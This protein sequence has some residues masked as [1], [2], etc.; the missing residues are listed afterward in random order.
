M[1]EKKKIKDLELTKILLDPRRIS[2]LDIAG[3]K[4]VTVTQMAEILNEKPSRLYY[5]VKKLEEAGFLE[6]VETKQQGN[7]IEKYYQTILNSSAHEF[8]EVLLHEHSE[9]VMKLLRQVVS[10]GLKLI[11]N[12]IT[13]SVSKEEQTPVQMSIIYKRKTIREWVESLADAT[14]AINNRPEDH[15]QVIEEELKR[16]PAEMMDK[17]SQYAYV[18]LSYRLEDAKEF[19]GKIPDVMLDSALNVQEED[20]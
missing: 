10:P 20:S 12:R 14:V 4:P 9:E 3:E 6:L 7:L 17:K 5:H 18:I 16:Y 11:E 19:G 2:I 15:A 13:N 1:L 8:D